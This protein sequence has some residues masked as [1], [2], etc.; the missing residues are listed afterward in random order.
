MSV[1]R[2]IESRVIDAPID[3]VWKQV[4]S[5]ELSFWS[6]IK[7]AKV[8]QGSSSEVGSLRTFA[9]KDGSV[10]QVKVVELSDLGHFLSFDFIQSEP[11]V[12]Y[13]S[14]LHTIHLRK[15]TNNNTTF[16]EWSAE[17][18]SD[19]KLDVI[20]DSKFKRLEGLEDL[21]KACAKK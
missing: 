1:T 16:V 2:V 11:A 6:A 12:G 10:Q 13:M 3:L 21:A 20:E 4:R 18:S 14:A 8:E 5:A 9:F 17:F 15:V 7:S 19:A